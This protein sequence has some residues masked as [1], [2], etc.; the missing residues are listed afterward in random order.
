MNHFNY[1]L[2][3]LEYLKNTF[4]TS[5][6]CAL[7][8]GRVKPFFYSKEQDHIPFEANVPLI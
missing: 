1:S 4:A 7:G 6:C 3:F 5:S 8:A 2:D